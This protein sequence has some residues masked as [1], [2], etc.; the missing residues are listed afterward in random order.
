MEQNIT[1]KGNVTVHTSDKRIARAL[2][3][4]E[5][6]RVEG[7]LQT[8]VVLGLLASIGLLLLILWLTR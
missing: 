4:P 3:S 2:S 6:D 1:T 5:Y 8:K 7:Q